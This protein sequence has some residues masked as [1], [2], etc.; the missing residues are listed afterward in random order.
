MAL[1][2]QRQKDPT[3]MLDFALGQLSDK[4][5]GAADN[6]LL[7]ELTGVLDRGTRGWADYAL[8]AVVADTGILYL[9]LDVRGIEWLSEGSFGVIWAI[10]KALKTRGGA[11][12]L[13]PSPAVREMVQT[14]GWADFI[15]L[16][17]E[18][19]NATVILKSVAGAVVEG[20][21]GRRLRFEARLSPTKC[22]VVRLE[23][24]LDSYSAPW[25]TASISERIEAGFINLD[26]DLS[27]C[28]SIGDSGVSCF[29]AILKLLKQSDGR[30]VLFGLDPKILEVFQLLGFAQF[31]EIVNTEE[32]ARAAL[33]RKREEPTAPRFPLIDKCPICGVR[34]RVAK[35]MRGRCRRCGTVLRVAPDGTVSLG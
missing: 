23:G 16:A 32:E 29:T 15:W 28:K 6:A 30:L 2:F 31:F 18:P 26:I 8:K 11:L 17:S 7:V 35:P 20:D 19:A 1:P 12:V 27:G 25:F 14:F 34:T 33:R 3:G 5:D 24:D 22:L 4:V 9:V 13:L 10:L 21:A